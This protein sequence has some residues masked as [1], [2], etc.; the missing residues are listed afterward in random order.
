MEIP[1]DV[2]AVIE[3]FETQLAKVGF[4][5]VDAAV[6]RR[7]ADEFR[8]EVAKVDRARAALEAAVAASDAKLTALCET[9][10]RAIAYALIYSQ[11]H[12]DRQELA[13]ALAIVTT[14]PTS[15]LTAPGPKKRGRPRKHNV[16][17]F[18]VPDPASATS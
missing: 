9:A 12:P 10:Q 6:L 3:L 1:D 5:D 2:R 16:E 15:T 13:D 18:S 14:P 4:P 11:S 7:Q 17:L 8:A